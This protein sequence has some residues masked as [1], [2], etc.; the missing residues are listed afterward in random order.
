[1]NIKLENKNRQVSGVA[2][3]WLV[4]FVFIIAL[5]YICKSRQPLWLLIPAVVCVPVGNPIKMLTKII[6]EVRKC[7]K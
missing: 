3:Y 7:S 2:Q 4:W 1:M 5:I 6:L